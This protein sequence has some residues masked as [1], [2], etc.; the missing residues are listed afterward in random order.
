MKLSWIIL[1]YRGLKKTS[2]NP[3][4]LFADR[5]QTGDLPNLKQECN[6]H[7]AKSVGFMQFYSDGA[8]YM[9]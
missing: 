3:W 5:S 1:R 2:T 9:V 6:H 8:N 7:L 4:I